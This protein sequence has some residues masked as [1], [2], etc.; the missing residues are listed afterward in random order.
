MD[1]TDSG[2]LP[3]VRAG[4]SDDDP[5][6][7]ER[8]RR[9]RGVPGCL[10]AIGVALALVV[11][12]GL[13][14]TK[15][16]SIVKDRLADAAD[17]PGPGSGSVAF[18]VDEGDSLSDIGR[19]LKEKGVVASVEAFTV[20]AAGDPAAAGVQVGTYELKK[21]MA[22]D[23]AV[24]ILADPANLVKSTFTVPEGLRIE[25]MLPLIAKETGIKQAEFEKVLATDQL[26]LP[27]WATKTRSPDGYPEGYLFPATYDI[28]P[29][30]DAKDLLVKMAD[31]WEQAVE[32]SGLRQAGRNLGYQPAEMMTIASLLQSEARP[33]D[34]P[35]V[36]RVLYNRLKVRG[37][38]Y[39]K[40]ELDSTVNYAHGKN[41]GTTTTDEERDLPSPYNTYASEGLPPTPISAPGLDALNAAARPANGSWFFFVTV[42]LQTG[43][44]KFAEN[45]AQHNVYVEE[46]RDYCREK[47]DQC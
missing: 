16:L 5:P 28:G 43:E 46:F 1:D 36:A 32:E 8:R 31:R 17:Y 33:P 41:L 30:D 14:I 4:A 39:F 38:T 6:T 15:G 13:G 29:K 20:A 22:A 2:I 24:A 9:R 3:I 23:D 27:R 19:A 37:E 10:I 11:A 40:L 42:N 12:L 35:R 34:M 21:E 25:E 18:E 47:S 26:G 7:T 44:T 45:L